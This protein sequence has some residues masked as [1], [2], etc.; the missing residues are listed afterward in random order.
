MLNAAALFAIEIETLWVSDAGGRLLHTRE[1][2]PSPA[3]DFVVAYVESETLCAFSSRVLPS[4]ARELESLASSPDDSPATRDS[5]RSLLEA[6]L[7]PVTTAQSL[8]YLIPA[9]ASYSHEFHI[10]TPSVAPDSFAPPAGAN[11]Q[12]DEWQALLAGKLGPWAAAIVEGSTAALCHTARLGPRGVEAGVFTAPDNRG[13]GLAAA[14]TTA[15]AS[16]F[17]GDDRQ[18]FY[19]TSIENL[20]SQRVAARLGLREIGT[21]WQF[22]A[23]TRHNV[24][25]A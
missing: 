11:W 6:H 12:D 15:W 20:A 9:S 1:A 14:V 22:F 4:L 25:H 19:S 18:V 17:A 2:S 5:I 3:P 23:G 24:G 21:M 7:G 16:Q 8:G 10:V 13:H